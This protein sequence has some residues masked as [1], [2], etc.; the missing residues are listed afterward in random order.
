MGRRLPQED[1]AGTRTEVRRPVDGK[2]LEVEGALLEPGGVV[3]Y[4]NERAET[5]LLAQSQTTARNHVDGN[6]KN[7]NLTR[8]R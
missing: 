1:A 3:N 8:S 7:Y 6:R 4:E 5:D 2:G